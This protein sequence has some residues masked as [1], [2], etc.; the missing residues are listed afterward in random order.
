MRSEVSGTDAA[1]LAA[2][3]VVFGSAPRPAHLVVTRRSRGERL[4]RTLIALVAALLAAPL[5]ALLPPHVPW[6]LAALIIGG[7]IARRQWLGEL[8]VHQFSGDCPRC[9][10]PLELDSS[11]ITLPLRVACLNCHHEPRL[12]SET[13]S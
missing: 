2:R 1:P 6:A 5:L 13:T 12:E 9:E 3:T 11:L 8:R 7:W 10:A 4:G